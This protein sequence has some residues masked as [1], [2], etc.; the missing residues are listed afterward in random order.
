MSFKLKSKG[1][2]FG[3]NE[4]LSTYSTPVFEKDLEEGILAEANR[5]GSTFVSAD[6]TDAQKKDAVEHE[7]VHH[8]QMDQGR[9]NYTNDTVM[10]KKNTQSPS[11]VYKR[12]AGQIIS[13]ETGKSEA[14]G[15]DFEWEKEAYNKEKK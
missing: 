11:R 13:M 1:K 7:N 14:E 5:D 4:E 3:I 15:G 8:E 9:L 6:A 2:L 12:E 10:W